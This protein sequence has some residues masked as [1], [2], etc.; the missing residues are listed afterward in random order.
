MKE[1]MLLKI[2]RDRLAAK[3][4]STAVESSPRLPPPIVG[5]GTKRTMQWSPWPKPEDDIECEKVNTS[6]L[7]ESSSFAAHTSAVSRLAM[8]D[9]LVA[10][11]SDEGTVKL[12]DGHNREVSLVG[13]SAFVSGLSFHPTCP[14]LVSSS[15]DGHI[16]IWNLDTNLCESTLKDHASCVWSVAVHPQAGD[17]LLAASL[18]HTAKLIDLSHSKCKQTFRGHVDSVN[19]AIFIHNTFTIATASADKSVSLWDVRTAHCVHTVFGHL[20]AVNAVAVSHTSSPVLASVDA[21]GLV[22]LTDIR[23]HREIVSVSMG[24]GNSGN[25]VEWID[26]A[27]VAVACKDSLIR[28][29]DTLSGNVTSTLSGHTLPV[30]GLAYGGHRLVSS[31]SSGTVKIWTS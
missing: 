9:S 10:T 31:D 14:R 11:A 16:K 23:T 27:T 19:M 30:L 26:G 18:D 12:L 8:K 13:H 24:T 28:L 3:L 25:A 15:G 22:R 21:E 7:H 17:W 1:K 2:D 4:Q 6:N 5:T 29:I 20:A